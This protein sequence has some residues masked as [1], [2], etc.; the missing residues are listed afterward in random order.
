MLSTSSFFF[1]FTV[2][3][4]LLFAFIA[5]RMCR[6]VARNQAYHMTRLFASFAVSL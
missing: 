4:L 1:F 2:H 5:S 3:C 6:F